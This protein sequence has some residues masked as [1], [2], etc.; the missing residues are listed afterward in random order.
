MAGSA[1]VPRESRNGQRGAP[2]S[3]NEENV[4]QALAKRLYEL[5]VASGPLRQS[6]VVDLEQTLAAF[7][8]PQGTLNIWC[9]NARIHQQALALRAS[10]GVPLRAPAPRDRVHFFTAPAVPHQPG[11]QE[12]AERREAGQDQHSTRGHRKAVLI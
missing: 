12:D 11:G 2:E 7:R 4:R 8:V 1:Q 6:G 9:G 10:G 5:E 3:V